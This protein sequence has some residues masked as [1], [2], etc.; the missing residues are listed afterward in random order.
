MN[1]EFTKEELTQIRDCCNWELVGLG[2]SDFNQNLWL[3]INR[4]IDNYCEHRNIFPEDQRAMCDD[5]GA[6]W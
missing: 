3:K 4:M 1:E 5:C 6:I 2:M